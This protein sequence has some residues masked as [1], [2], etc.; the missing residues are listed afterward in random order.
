M[1]S[2]IV[3][4]VRVAVYRIVCDDE[5]DTL[6]EEREVFKIQDDLRY[7]QPNFDRHSTHKDSGFSFISL[8][9]REYLS[10][11]QA[12]H[13]LRVRFLLCYLGSC[14][15]HVYFANVESYTHAIPMWHH[16]VITPVTITLNF[17]QTALLRD[18]V[19]IYSFILI[20]MDRPAID[21]QVVCEEILERHPVIL[22][23]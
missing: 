9:G 19:N 8:H 15:S 4:H 5:E 18:Q 17:T 22:I 1:C 23:A 3:R 6:E 10:L 16:A 7:H 13:H 14:L 21:L 11:A 12:K 2:L 20:L